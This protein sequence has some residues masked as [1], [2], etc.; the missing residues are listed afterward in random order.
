MKDLLLPLVALF[1]LTR[2]KPQETTTKPPTGP[3][4]PT[5]TTQPQWTVSR[6]DIR[7]EEVRRNFGTRRF[8]RRR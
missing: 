7:K 2:I 4:G 8:R 5:G 6:K 1:L 3:T